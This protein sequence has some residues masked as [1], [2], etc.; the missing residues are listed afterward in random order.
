[1]GANPNY[2]SDAP[3]TIVMS[4][5]I[6][7]AAFFFKLWRAWL[8]VGFQY[9]GIWV[10]SCFVMQA[11]FG[12]RLMQRLS[13]DFWLSLFGCG[14]FVIAT[15]FLLRVYLHPAL[16][17]QWVLL[18][19][20]Y[21]GLDKRPRTLAWWG[22]LLF[23]TLVHAYLLV[24]VAALWVACMFHHARFRSMTPLAMLG[25]AFAVV[26]SI[27]LT[28]L[29]AG[30]F[31]PEAVVPLAQRTYTNL[32]FPVWPGFCFGAQWSQWSW[33]MP[34]T[35]FDSIGKA[36]QLGDGF[37]YFGL[38]YLALAVIALVLLGLGKKTSSGWSDGVW[39]MVMVSLLLVM[40][41]IGDRVYAGTRLLFTIHWPGVLDYA[42]HVFRGGGRMIWPAWYLCMFMV[43]SVVV[44]G[45]GV[46]RA[47]W[48]L[49][50]ALLVQCADMSMA[51]VE[52]QRAIKERTVG[53]AQ[54]ASPQW[55][56]LDRQFHHAV[57]IRSDKLSA[58]LVGWSP[59]YRRL[60][61]RAAHDGLSVNI[62]YLSRMNES[63]LDAARLKREAL[64][65]NG[66]AE[67][68][69]F[70]VIDDGDLWQR[71]LC[72]PDHGQWHGVLDGMLL[73]VPDPPPNLTL[74]PASVSHAC[75]G[76]PA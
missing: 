16:A 74:P 1:L 30:Y 57:F 48:V 51:A 10:L 64:L 71:I 41:A 46:N 39:P 44:C 40:Y 35:K 70:Y 73:L 24:M 29:A 59:D 25:Y 3:G 32:L 47:R 49:L 5:S 75:A 43:L 60:A 27:V 11:W 7:V 36:M 56:L 21:L 14:L 67:P 69:T 52:S 68:S 33:V 63:A 31:V 13:G 37:G 42:G 2:G 18:A 53:I 28:M 9:F 45:L 4:D 76:K 61:L 62:G 15:I 65:L 54:L 19:A 17:A 8:P 20:I 58:Y 26:C 34:C 55:E 23:T 22:L 12:Y 66:Q 6:P 72:A 38:G 50:L